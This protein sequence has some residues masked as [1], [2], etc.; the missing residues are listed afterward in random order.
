[1]EKERYKL[2]YDDSQLGYCIVDTEIELCDNIHSW[3]LLCDLL[4]QQDE[5]IK[6]LEEENKI[7]FSLTQLNDCV[8]CEKKAIEYNQM[9]VEENQQLKEQYDELN[10]KYCEEMD[11][12][13]ALVEQLKQSQNEKAIEELEK[14]IEYIR[15]CETEP[16]YW[17]ISQFTY[18]QIKELKGKR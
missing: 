3:N 7:L 8:Y 15:N 1:M 18:N 6:E 13:I 9:L 4:N 5:K 2:F 12:N 17:D 16:R 11:K 14:I 10:K